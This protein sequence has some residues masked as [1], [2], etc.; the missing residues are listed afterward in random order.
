MCAQKPKN[1]DETLERERLE[2]QGSD[3]GLKFLRIMEFA[4]LRRVRP[5]V[6]EFYGLAPDF[7]SRLFPLDSDGQPCSMPW[8]YSSMLEYFLLD[9]EDF[10][11]RNP[12][13]GE[14]VNSGIWLEPEGENGVELP[15]VAKAWQIH[16]HCQIMSIQVIHEE[17]AERV[18]LLRKARLELVERRKISND[19][20]NFKKQ[21]LYDGMTK[22]YN[23]ASFMEIIQEQM[24]KLRTYAPTLALF[25]IDVD[26]FKI[27]NDTLGHLVGDSVLVQVADLLRTSLRKND[28]P[29]RYGGDEFTVVAPDTNIDQSHKL[30]EKLRHRVQSHKFNTGNIPVTI[31]VG[32]TIFRSGESAQNFIR[33]ADLALYDAKLM[34][35]N[36]AC[37]RDPWIIEDDE[38]NEMEEAN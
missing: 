2:S 24:D 23:R 17:Y 1:L 16:K 30:A 10:F 37:F 35:R 27:V 5:M 15:L 34:G 38:I 26:N 3:L 31:S 11:E 25:I 12:R 7:Y 22:L 19:L 4:I 20:N 13:I 8:K 9:A 18:N 36:V 14:K 29:A 28:F 21:A 6:Y 32:Y 33:R